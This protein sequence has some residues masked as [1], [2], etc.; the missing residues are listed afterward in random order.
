[1]RATNEFATS[2]SVVCKFRNWDFHQDEPKILTRAKD[3]DRKQ[4]SRTISGLSSASHTSSKSVLLLH[5]I[6]PQLSIARVLID[7]VIPFES[8]SIKMVT[9]DPDSYVAV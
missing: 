1:M 8:A 4:R 9:E 2:V 6:K 7:V 5:L 3:R